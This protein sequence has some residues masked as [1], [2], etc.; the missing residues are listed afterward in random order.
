[1]RENKYFKIEDGKAIPVTEA[2]LRDAK[3]IHLT[4]VSDI[5]R[6][7]GT[8]KKDSLS[9]YLF[10]KLISEYEYWT[11]PE[12]SDNPPVGKLIELLL[13]NLSDEVSFASIEFLKELA[14][15]K[16]GSKA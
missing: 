3:R 13:K 12:Y 10:E 16:H 7:R 8:L 2:D 9:L 4:N 14:R 6:P 1:M 5:L 11:D 15:R